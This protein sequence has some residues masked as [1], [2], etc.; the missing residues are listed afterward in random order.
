MNDISF[1]KKIKP[2][3]R[4]IIV[5]LILI[6]LGILI[7]YIFSL[8]SLDILIDKIEQLPIQIDQ[9]RIDRSINY[10]MGAVI[11]L[12]IELILL[13]GVLYVY[14]DSYLNVLNYIHISPY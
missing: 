10:Y 7:G 3:T 2:R 9:T 14:I 1:I 6:L 11:I 4:A 5:L 12:T 13:I 8:V